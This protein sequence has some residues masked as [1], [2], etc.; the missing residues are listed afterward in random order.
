MSLLTSDFM[1][2]VGTMIDVAQNFMKGHSNVESDCAPQTILLLTSNLC[3]SSSLSHASCCSP[4]RLQQG[5]SWKL[6]S[7]DLQQ[8]HK[9]GWWQSS[10]SQVAV[11]A[12]VN[13]I[14]LPRRGLSNKTRLIASFF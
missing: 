5:S 3:I 2:A 4:L 11:R 8:C 12:V 13:T 14:Q 9:L 7:V 6:Q 10:L 1:D